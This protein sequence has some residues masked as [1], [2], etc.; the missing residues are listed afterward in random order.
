MA[1]DGMHNDRD[2]MKKPRY[3][4]MDIARVAGQPRREDTRPSGRLSRPMY[5]NLI[6]PDGG[7]MG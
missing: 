1:A 5:R 7:A 6:I 3:V 2:N 4:Q